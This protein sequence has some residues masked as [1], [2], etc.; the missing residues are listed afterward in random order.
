MIWDCWPNAQAW[1]LACKA[2]RT[3]IAPLS[4]EGED[5]GRSSQTRGKR[6]ARARDG[7]DPR[8]LWVAFNDAGEIYSGPDVQL[9]EDMT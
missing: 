6:L 2:A 8:A 5:R 1:S 7:L 9:V 4:A 3:Q